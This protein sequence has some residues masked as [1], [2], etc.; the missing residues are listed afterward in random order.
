M[1]RIVSFLAPPQQE[2]QIETSYD[3]RIVPL[4]TLR[5]KII[6]LVQQLIKL[7]NE[8][9]LLAVGRSEFFGKLSALVE[10]YPWNNFLHLKVISLYED[11]VS[12]SNSEFLRTALAS[13]NIG[14][15]LISLGAKNNFEYQSNR[16]IRHGY[17][18]VVIKI[19]NAIT[20][21]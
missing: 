5:L 21:N 12:S 1:T 9:I 8:S 20:K 6:E 3:L 7:S 2:I 15:T 18:S 10:A 4:G 17:M 16:P 13:S 19:A 11:L 14:E